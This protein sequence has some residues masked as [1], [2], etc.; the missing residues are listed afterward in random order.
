MMSEEYKR[1]SV[2]EFDRAAGNFDDDDPNEVRKEFRFHCVVR[3]LF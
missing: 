3:K 1:L 2:K